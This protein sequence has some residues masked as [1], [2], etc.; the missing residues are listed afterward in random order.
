MVCDGVCRCV[1][2]CSIFR[3]CFCFSRHFKKQKYANGPRLFTDLMCSTT[4]FHSRPFLTITQPLH[5]TSRCSALLMPH[6]LLHSILPVSTMR[7]PFFQQRSVRLPLLC[8]AGDQRRMCW[9]V[10]EH[11][12]LF[13]SQSFQ[14][15]ALP[16]GF[17]PSPRLM[18]ART[19][20]RALTT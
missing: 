10:F 7:I 3:P 4:L 11:S 18:G 20:K 13:A 8:G 9:L 19:W 15:C 1:Q 14:G 17:C 2:A 16:K 6:M 12:R 5:L